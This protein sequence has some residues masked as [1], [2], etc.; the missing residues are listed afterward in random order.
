MTT[1]VHRSRRIALVLAVLLMAFGVGLLL[2]H[3][4]ERTTRDAALR[5]A[6]LADLPSTATNI[7]VTSDRRFLFC[8]VILVF[9]DSEPAIDRWLAESPGIERTKV[10]GEFSERDYYADSRHNMGAN[11][12]VGR[13]SGRVDI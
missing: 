13:G 11:V 5:S 12:Q 6:G 10:D 9:Y 1:E 4:H 7:V 2:A 3:L 8:E